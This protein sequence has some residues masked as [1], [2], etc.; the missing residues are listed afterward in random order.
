[1]RHSAFGLR[2]GGVIVESEL[3]TVEHMLELRA[4]GLSQACIATELNLAGY[5]SRWGAYWT[6]SSVGRTLNR[7]DEYRELLA[8]AG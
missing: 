3:K 4:K 2:A 7:A 5:R 8:T 1:M 6:V